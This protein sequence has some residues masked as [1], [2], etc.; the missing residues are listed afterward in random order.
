MRREMKWKLFAEHVLYK[1]VISERILK[2]LAKFRRLKQAVRKLEILYLEY[3]QRKAQN[4]E[5]KETKEE[6]A[7]EHLKKL[8]PEKVGLLG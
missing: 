4:K 1:Q 7:I 3:K 2:G 6:I 5:M 8:S